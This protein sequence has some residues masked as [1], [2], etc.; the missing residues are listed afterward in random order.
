MTGR[1]ISL[2]SGRSAGFIEA[3]NG[4]RL[5]FDLGAVLAYD[6]NY[7]SIGQLVT[8]EI[9]HGQSSK[10]INICVQRPSHASTAEGKRKESMLRYVGFEQI[11]TIRTYRFERTSLGEQT[12]IFA[13]NTDIALF[14]KY[15][16]GIQ[17]GPQL[18]LRLL[19]VGL[20]NAGVRAL[21]RSL[22]EEDIASHV[23]SR[24]A[25]G[26]RPSHKKSA[27]AAAASQAV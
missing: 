25:P 12:E 17:E 13:V 18:C 4:A 14:T 7:L 11:R 27:R 5:H 24:P 21:Q 6:V 22:T 19:T 2:N 15:H 16:V 9:E 10:A 1:I 8:F 26:T 3:E 20:E 23:A